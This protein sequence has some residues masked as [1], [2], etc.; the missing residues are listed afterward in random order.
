MQSEKVFIFIH[1][2]F[3]NLVL[4][5]T[6]VKALMIIDIRFVHLVCVIISPN[7]LCYGEN[8]TDNM[9]GHLCL[10]MLGFLS[11]GLS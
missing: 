1:F 7:I 4:E 6:P 9:G 5:H 3:Y 11:T 10:V 8:K 2:M